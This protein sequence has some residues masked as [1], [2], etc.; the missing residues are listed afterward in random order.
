MLNISNQIERGASH[1][2]DCGV[3]IWCTKLGWFFRKKSRLKRN[4]L[5]WRNAEVTK[6]A[7]LGFPDPI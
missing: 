1:H 5:K 6:M 2:F 4:A 7:K 3:T